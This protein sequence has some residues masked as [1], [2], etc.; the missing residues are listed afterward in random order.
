MRI[1]GW[2]VMGACLLGIGLFPPV[3]VHAQS[4]LIRVGL[5]YGKT[6]PTAITLAPDQS[7]ASLT[8]SV[9]ATPITQFSNTQYLRITGYGVL[10]GTH[11]T[12]A[13]ALTQVASLRNQGNPA[14]F[15]KTTVS[16]VIE[17]RVKVGPYLDAQTA[18]SKQASLHA[19]TAVGPYGVLYGG[20]YANMQAAQTAEQ[21]AESFGHSVRILYNGTYQVLIGQ[22]VSAQVALTIENAVHQ[23][24]P[25]VPLTIFS[26]MGTEI[27]LVTSSARVP[28]VFGGTTS[29]S[30]TGSD[31]LVMLGSTVYR[32]QIQPFRNN[33]LMT[34]VNV[35]PIEQYL[36]GVVPSEMPAS[37]RMQALQAQAIAART[38]AVYHLGSYQSQGFDVTGDTWSQAYGGYSAENPRTTQAVNATRGIV[39]TYQGKPINAVFEADSGG[40][41]ASDINVWGKNV[42]YLIGVPEISGFVSP[43]PW[44]VS[45]TS[46]QLQAILANNGINIGNVVNMQITQYTPHSHRAMALTFTGTNGIYTSHMDHIR[47]LLGVKSTMFNIVSGGTNT[48]TQPTVSSQ[49]SV[50][51]PPV[52]VA[53]VPG[54]ETSLSV[55]TT[56]P[57]YVLSASGETTVQQSTPLY[58][59]SA[60]NQAP[61]SFV[62]A[63]ATN[64]QTHAYTTATPATQGSNVYVLKG[65]GWGHGLGMSQDGAEYMAKKGYTYQQILTHYYTG[66]QLSPSSW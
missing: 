55:S 35:L 66:I 5:L 62:F 42:P 39:A 54:Q 46:N 52:Y 58:V 53:P 18:I 31:G 20:P 9:G 19:G 28:L 23:K 57:M 61:A 37:W 22:A 51:H 44:T 8:I 17:Y 29:L 47:G 27:S 1:R 24:T 14:Y 4:T 12:Q 32:G 13:G 65:S 2:L 10:M 26:P 34:V 63:P 33:N 41:T 50:A 49:S 3:Q 64:V 38:Y 59:Q 6:R 16:G 45:F 48:A 25:T 40:Y 15:E 11:K 43:N 7:G 36:Y 60:V 21:T 30:V 56:Q